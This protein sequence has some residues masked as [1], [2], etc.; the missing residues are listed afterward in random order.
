MQVKYPRHP[1]PAPAVDHRFVAVTNGTRL[2]VLDAR[3][4]SSRT[5]RWAELPVEPRF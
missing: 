2:Y 4:A 1:E 3:R 5:N